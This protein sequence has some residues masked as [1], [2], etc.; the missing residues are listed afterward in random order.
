M[1]GNLACAE[2]DSWQSTPVVEVKSK[3]ITCPLAL[4][5]ASICPRPCSCALRVADTA[6]IID[7][8]GK[9][10]TEA[11]AALPMSPSSNHTELYLTH[12]K[13]E[14]LPDFTQPGYEMVSRLALGSNNIT[15]IHNVTNLPKILQVRL[16]FSGFSIMVT[17]FIFHV[18]MLRL[19]FASR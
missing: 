11:P 17:Q 16:F 12:N 19:C 15:K 13:L 5:A 10:L 4:S 9:N 6:L 8:I 18:L 1:P 7:C 3:A 2:P 14:K